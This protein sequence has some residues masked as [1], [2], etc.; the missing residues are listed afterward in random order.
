[1]RLVHPYHTDV[2]TNVKR[3]H[4]SAVPTNKRRPSMATAA[5]STRIRDGLLKCAPTRGRTSKVLRAAGPA[6]CVGGMAG[7]VEAEA[8]GVAW[9]NRE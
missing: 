1:M 2:Y 8:R 4:P 7:R 3:T 6:G 5:D 9:N